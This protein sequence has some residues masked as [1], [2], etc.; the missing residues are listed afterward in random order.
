MTGSAISWANLRSRLPQLR[1][2]AEKARKY[3]DIY[4]EKESAPEYPSRLYDI[5]SSREK[6]DECEGLWTAAKH[7]LDIA[8]DNISARTAHRRRLSDPSAAQ[9][10]KD[11]KSRELREIEEKRQ[12]LEGDVRVLENE[13]AYK[14]HS[15]S[16]DGSGHPPPGSFEL[17]EKAEERKDR[18][19]SRQ[20]E[21]L[22]SDEVN[23]SSRSRRKL[24]ETAELEKQQT[25]FGTKA[26]GQAKAERRRIALSSARSRPP[27]PKRAK[28]LPAL[29]RKKPSKTR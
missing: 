10:G 27:Q 16:E 28:E 8:D 9:S 17:E 2:D 11:R 24:S 1:I 26:S 4:E 18:R 6:A 21:K 29:N 22:L 7:R 12:K 3:L 20:L 13:R 25:T 23:R 14:K 15:E 19:R 5:V